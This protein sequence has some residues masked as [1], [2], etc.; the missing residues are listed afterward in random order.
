MIGNKGALT[1]LFVY[2]AVI[3]IMV[4]FMVAMTFIANTTKTELLKN[5]NMF[6]GKSTSYNATTLIERTI[7]GVT[8]AYEP[9]KWISVML[10]IGFALSILVTSFLV[11]TN[12]VF[13]V[14]YAIIVMIAVILSVPVSNA[15]EVVYNNPTLHSTFVGFFGAS[16]IFSYLPIWIAVI[17][18]LAGV[19]M[20]VNVIRS[21][22]M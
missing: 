7:G 22:P 10:M 15:Y 19:L 5:T 2:V 9:L 17:G 8:S 18:L 21:E 13:F 20:F 3:F 16:Y 12:P 11:R 4:L 1:D 6:Q 14:P